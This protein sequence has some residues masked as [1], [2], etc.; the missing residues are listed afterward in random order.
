MIIDSHCHA[1]ETWP[2][3]QRVPDPDS[4]GR[5]EQ[6][7]YEMDLNGVDRALVV[8]AQI[9]HNPENNAY[10]A[11]CVE[12]YP[13]RLVQ[14]ADLDSSWS[15]TYRT[16]GADE[17]LRTMVAQWPIAGFTHYLAKDD[18]GGW[19]TGADGRALFREAASRR[20][21]ASVSCYPHQQESIR[22]LADAFPAVPIL[23]HHLGHPRASDREPQDGLKEILATARCRNVS[24]K[25]SGFS[26]ASESTWDFPFSDVRRI[27]GALYEHFGPDRLLWGSDYP[28]VRGRMTYRQSI[29]VVRSHCDFIPPADRTSILGP[30]LERLLAGL[31]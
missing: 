3:S 28:V 29:E 30:S 1:W 2:Y 31:R 10:V 9:D 21:L 12:R 22:R 4:R 8:S 16:A 25:V 17:R 27:V 13:D 5:V 24:I 15:R 14:V 26:Y 6:L 23:C 20:L 7:L 18:D 11:E 19:L